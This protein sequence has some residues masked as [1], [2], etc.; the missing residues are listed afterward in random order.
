MA[1]SS[2][3]YDSVLL[4][5]LQS[6]GKIHHFL[7]AIFGFLYRKTDFYR[8]LRDGSDKLG[9]PP[10]VAE[11][12]AYGSFKRFKDM[13][14][15]DEVERDKLLQLKAK[16]IQEK[17][18]NSNPPP[19]VQEEEVS[20]SASQPSEK[21]SNDSEVK[22]QSTEQKPSID[23][24]N[25][26]TKKI[27]DSPEGEQGVYQAKADCY[28]GA[29]LENYAW[30]QTITDLDLRVYVSKTTKKGK[31]IS[32]SVNRKSIKVVQK[33]QNE[34]R[35]LIDGKFAWDVR[36]DECVWSLVPGEYVHI[37]LEKIEERW[38]ESALKG[39]PTINVRKIDAS[40]P[41]TDLDDEA[42][43]K[44]EE[45]M[46]NEQMKRLG[47]PQSHEKKVHEMLKQAWDAE[48]SPF[49]GQP[50]DPSLV[51]VANPNSQQPF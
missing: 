44:I 3:K 31:E 50:F 51:N 18:L 14:D 35:I 43:A 10:G 24:K 6:E 15:K 7:E 26:E 11:K 17:A 12:I 39:E 2:E 34:D 47:K 42:Q 40:R 16:E 28:N 1:S 13:A 9:F 4:G 23:K 37:N 25:T 19:V 30:S 46:Y 22:D 38:W 8:L 32:V 48:G 36:A 41:I 27:E 49:K 33:T 20:T 45:M 5:I 29:E 21:K